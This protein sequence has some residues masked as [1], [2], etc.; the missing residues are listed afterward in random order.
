MENI[1]VV[2]V[3]PIYKE[4]RNL[5]RFEIISLRE[6]FV[7]LITHDF[8][9]YAPY[10]LNI[11]DYESFA[12]QYKK[13]INFVFFRDDYFLNISGYSKLMLS[14]N[15]YK[16]FDKYDYLLIYQLDAFIFRDELLYWC[17]K[18]YDYIGAPW[19]D[20]KCGKVKE[21]K[22]TGVG[23]GGF[24]LRKISKMIS[25]LSSKRPFFNFRQLLL[26]HRDLGENLI[27]SF[28]KA[29]IKSITGHKNNGC[30]FAQNFQFD[31]DAFW[32]EI[33]PKSNYSI[34]IG[35][36]EDSMKFSF[37][38]APRLLY[39]LNSFKLPF[40]CHGWNK[41]DMEFWNEKMDFSLNNLD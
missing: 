16:T 24:C 20:D 32:A 17:E 31:E 28:I 30:Y 13:K 10:S 22:I 9:F 39:E 38:V 37:E 5:D 8:I 6:L 14:L 4:F 26:L 34:N 18:G 33:V 2:V 36:I 35:T 40:G 15:F 1:T 41:Y 11:N 25:I 3:I 23:N 21:G 19:F 12:I 29:L 27:N 7:K